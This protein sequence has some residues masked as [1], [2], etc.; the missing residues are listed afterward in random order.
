VSVGRPLT[1]REPER[2]RPSEF[3]LGN[4]MDRTLRQAPARRTNVPEVRKDYGTSID[5][6]QTVDDFDKYSSSVPNVLP[7]S[8][9]T[10]G[11]FA[12][13]GSIFASLIL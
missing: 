8:T 5:G 1:S 3:L 9:E 6:T 2:E 11:N 13:A 7:V 4:R 12:W 10:P